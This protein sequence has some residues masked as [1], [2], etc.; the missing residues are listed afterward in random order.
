MGARRNSDG[1]A[2]LFLNHELVGTVESQPVVNGR[3]LRGAFVSRYVLA[4]DGRSVLSGDLAYKS[5]FQDDTFVGPIATT[6]N[7][8]PAFTRFCSGSL[9]G[10]EAGFD[11]PIYF[12]SEESSTGTFS[13]RGPQSVAIFRNNS[14]VG[15]AHALSRLGYFPWENA[16]VSARND[17]LTVIMSMEDGPATLDNQLYMYVGKKQRGGSVLSRNG[18]NN[19]A[20]YAFRSSD[21]AKN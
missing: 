14:G 5:V 11:R 12:A 10:R 16:L 7:T 3:I 4:G 21:L 1:T 2:T 17:S 9:S 13:A 8:T 6:A 19:G 20:L 18:L 15:E